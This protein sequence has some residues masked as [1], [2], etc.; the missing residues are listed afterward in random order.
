[1]KLV[2]TGG[3][4]FIGS[5]LVRHLINDWG[6]TVLNIDKLSYAANLK[7][8]AA[9]SNKAQYHFSQTDI[10]DKP[11]LEQ[12]IAEFQPDGIFHLAAE[13][14][15]DRS[16]A[17]P[18]IFVR[19]N[20]L[21]T[22][23]MLS[24]TQLYLASSPKPD[25]FR[26]LHISTDE[27]FGEL[28]PNGSDLF[29]ETTPYN[30]RSPY[31]ASKAG[32]DHL[33]RAWVNTYKF[34]ALITNCSNNY[35]PF[36]NTE[37]L[38]PQTISNALKKKNIPVYG[39]GNQVRDWLYVEDHVRGLYE[40]FL[41]GQIGSSYNI[42]GHNERSNIDVVRTICATLDRLRPD[43]LDGHMKSHVDLIAFVADRPGHDFR[44]AIDASKMHREF[45]WMPLESFEGGLEKTI[46]WYL[47]YLSAP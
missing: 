11:A 37:K 32:S 36:Q 43:D 26:F 4:G 1:M 2:V 45:G 16:I 10:L 44:Y 3:A 9:V 29:T 42:G 18:D 7:A 19:T 31:A 46:R 22:Q 14:H 30:P 33:V 34:P 6:H 21:G 5:S 13:T 23:N 12:L 39:K 8:L 28:S 27:V 24:A 25:N 41:K 35:G 38:I 20:V 17:D 15:V 40:V 47:D